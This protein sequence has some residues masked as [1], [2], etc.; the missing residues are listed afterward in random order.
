M[1]K[2][3]L[4]YPEENAVEIDPEILW[5]SVK[6][7]INVRFYKT[8]LIYILKFEIFNFVYN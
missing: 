6:K 3:Q 1:E 8:H 5:N 2:M 4:E 7:V